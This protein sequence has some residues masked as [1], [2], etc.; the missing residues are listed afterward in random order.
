VSKLDFPEEIENASGL[1]Q[2][3]KESID[4]ASLPIKMDFAS[5]LF[6][7]HRH[8]SDDR[9]KR[10]CLHRARRGASIPPVRKASARR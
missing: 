8:P 3:K 9:C 5:E 2:I 4:K 6:A 7:Q 10:Q 1:T